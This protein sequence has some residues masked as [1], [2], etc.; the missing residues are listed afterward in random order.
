MVDGTGH[1]RRLCEDFRYGQ[2]YEVP[3]SIGKASGVSPTGSQNLPESNPPFPSNPQNLP[4]SNLPFPS[5]PQNIPPGTQIPNESP[6]WLTDLVSKL[7][8]GGGMGPGN[9]LLFLCVKNDF[10]L[11]F[12]GRCVEFSAKNSVIFRCSGLLKE[13]VECCQ[14]HHI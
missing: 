1:S 9:A 5:N 11:P 14:R 10:M 4:E 3:F 7:V 13:G 8:M 2:M 6:Q 12:V